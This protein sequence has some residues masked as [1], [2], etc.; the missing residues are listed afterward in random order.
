MVLC[1]RKTIHGSIS[2]PIGSDEST[3]IASYV[4]SGA[5]LKN[6]T[7]ESGRKTIVT[8]GIRAHK[9]K[10]L[11]IS[12]TTGNLSNRQISTN[13]IVIMAHGIINIPSPT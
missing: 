3:M 10:G 6:S 4:P 12:K 1:S 8:Y 7:A 9:L 5:F 13:N 2:S 11:P